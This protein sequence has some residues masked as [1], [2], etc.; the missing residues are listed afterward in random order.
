MHEFAF[1]FAGF[2]VGLVV[3]LTGV[4]GG[5][6]MTPLL[7]FVFGIKPH[8]AIG[9]D[10]LF[11]AFTKMGGT[12]SLARARIVDWRIVGQMAAG[13]IPASLLTL[14]VLQRLG[15]ANPATQ[16]LMTTTLGLALLLT[17]CATLYKALRGKAAPAHIST[18][19]LQQ[20]TRARHW[21][22][23]LLFGAVIGS[24]VTLTSVGAGAIGVIVLMLLY[25]ALPLP[26]IVAADIAHAVPLT[27][28]AGLGHASIGSV[29]WPLLLK[30]LA[31]S[32]PGIWLGS[33]LMRKTPE[34]VIRSL[35]SLLLAYAGA[36]LISL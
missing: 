14:Y 1:I 17:A 5:S 22:L 11:A 6:L 10:L 2:S 24:L 29:D 12:V 33:Q 25:P 7:I 20:A 30:L 21:A 32:L 35:L 4:G 19:S 3:G 8:L 31:G 13:S 15:P 36:K 18:E 27:L 34:R 9:T 16:A 26:R 28:V 23:P